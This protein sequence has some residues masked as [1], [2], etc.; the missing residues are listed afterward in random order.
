MAL[1]HKVVA[2]RMDEY[3][4]KR[5]Q[6]RCDRQSIGSCSQ[7]STSM[8]ALHSSML[9][10]KEEN[11]NIPLIIEDPEAEEGAEEGEENVTRPALASID[12]NRSNHQGSALTSLF[13][14]SGHSDVVPIGGSDSGNDEPSKDTWLNFSCSYFLRSCHGL[15]LISMEDL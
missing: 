13:E 8:S 11:H 3:E 12:L 1:C 7:R 4:S 9:S 6:S 14:Y 2:E 15:K 5:E 10:P